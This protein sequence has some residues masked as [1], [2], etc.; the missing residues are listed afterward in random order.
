MG[1]N[2]IKAFEQYVRTGIIL[3]A[4]SA[5]ATLARAVRGYLELPVL[6]MTKREISWKNMD[7]ASADAREAFFTGVNTAL[8]AYELGDGSDNAVGSYTAQRNRLARE[9]IANR[10]HTHSYWLGWN[11]D[12]SPFK[13]L[14]G[15]MK[16]GEY[17]G[18]MPTAVFLNADARSAAGLSFTQE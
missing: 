8:C 7:R 12:V 2:Q 16:L 4:N 13:L 5:P 10:C 15:N 6:H 17:A 3:A 1:R 18:P 11:S 14:L 9:A